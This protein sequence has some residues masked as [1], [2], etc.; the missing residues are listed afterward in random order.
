MLSFKDYRLLQESQGAFPLG[1]KNPAAVALINS[2][3]YQVLDEKKKMLGNPPVP[4][5]DEAEETDDEV[6]DDDEEADADEVE[7]DDDAD[8]VATDMDDGEE[9][10]DEPS[11]MKKKMKKKMKKEENEWQERLNKLFT[12]G[13]DENGKRKKFWNGVKEDI[14]LPEPNQVKPAVPATEDE[15]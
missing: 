6:D 10:I 13:L 9:D 8:D 14:L 5:D 3:L 4:A 15:E 2:P 7:P 12:A 1:I 11:C